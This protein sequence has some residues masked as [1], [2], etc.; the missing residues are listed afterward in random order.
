[1]SAATFGAVH[2]LEA[3]GFERRQAKAITAATDALSPRTL[4]RF[5]GG[6]LWLPASGVWD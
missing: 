1:M 3:A 2:D 4:P 5:R 6:R